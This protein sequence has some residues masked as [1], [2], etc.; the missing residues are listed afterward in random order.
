MGV[1]V[2]DGRGLVL[3][4]VA[5][6]G[7]SVL[8]RKGLKRSGRGFIGVVNQSAAALGRREETRMRRRRAVG[9]ASGAIKAAAAP[10]AAIRR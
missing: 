7:G 5:V 2:A 3:G 4:S 9:G 1:P 10:P 6:R 8:A